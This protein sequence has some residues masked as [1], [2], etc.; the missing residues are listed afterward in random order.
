MATTEQLELI[1]ELVAQ[2]RVT[3]E[4]L[5]EPVEQTGQVQNRN[6][7]PNFLGGPN[8]IAAGLAAQLQRIGNRVLPGEPFPDTLAEQRQAWPT[9][10]AIGESILPAATGLIPGGLAVQTGLG[11]LTGGLTADDAGSGALTGAGFSVAGAA[12]GNLTGRAV[13]R[14]RGVLNSIGGGDEAS[15]LLKRMQDLGFEL[16]PG[17]ITQ[18]RGTRLLE[19]GLKSQPLT[20]GA[21]GRMLQRNQRTLNG[22]A[23]RSIGQNADN[24]GVVVRD[25]AADALGEVFDEVGRSIDAVEIPDAMIADLAGQGLPGRF[26]RNTGLR[27]DAT[28]FITGEQAMTLRSQLGKASRSAWRNGDAVSGEVLDDL[29][30]ELDA[31]MAV[32]DELAEQWKIAREQWRN[33][34]ALEQGAALSAEGNVNAASLLRNQ[35][36]VFGERPSSQLMPETQDLLDATRGAASQA[37]GDIV[38][39]SGTSTRQAVMQALGMAS[40]GVG[41]VA[42]LGAAPAAGEAFV[43]LGASPTDELFQQVGGALGRTGAGEFERERSR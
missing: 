36:R 27:G 28:Q 35:R 11:A 9:E 40:E 31:R 18:N 5:A 7:L 3:E 21:F 20:G 25:K 37:Y 33:L 39:D 19:A 12:A 34:I 10:T 30:L 26:L 32:P 2:Q 24:V 29:V 42:T 38:P 23:A 22:L 4:I 13:N 15:R 1:R 41:G 6:E 16:S 43:R 8:A 17:Q 14:A